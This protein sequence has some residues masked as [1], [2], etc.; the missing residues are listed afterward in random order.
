MAE[1]PNSGNNGNEQDDWLRQETHVNIHTLGGI[2]TCNA[3]IL[4][5][6]N[7]VYF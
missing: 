1:T 7:C 3:S 5:A 4:S 6:R 2:E